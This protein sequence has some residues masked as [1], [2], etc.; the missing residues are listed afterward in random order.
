MSQD[1]QRILD[2]VVALWNTGAPDIATRIYTDDCP[3]IDPN[4]PPDTRGGPA[5]A[6]YVTEVR[7]AYP[8]FKLEVLDSIA[9]GDRLAVHW[10]VTGTHK[11]DFRGIAPTGKQI[12]IT[13]MTLARV[14]DG[15]LAEDR[16]YFDRMTMFEQLGVV[17]GAMQTQTKGL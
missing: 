14:K 4:V 9:E 8:D 13:G 1:V 12:R 2:S 10:V 5:I 11:G 3:R 6:R 15:K 7:S 17:P 16:V